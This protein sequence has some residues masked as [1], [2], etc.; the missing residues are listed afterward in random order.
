[1]QSIS[2]LRLQILMGL[3]I[4][5]FV[6]TQS[7][8]VSNVSSEQDPNEEADTEGQIEKIKASEAVTTSGSQINLGFQSILLSEVILDDKNEEKR[9]SRDLY[10]ALTKKAFKILFRRIISTNAP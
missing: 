6:I 8:V 3:I 4:G 10:V 1:M 9:S 7:T 5:L 2:P